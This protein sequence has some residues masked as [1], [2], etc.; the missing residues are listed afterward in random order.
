[1]S[2]VLV[3]G[4]IA[5]DTVR[6]PKTER[7][8]VLGGSCT[9]FAVAAS[10]LAGVQV[11][12]AVGEDFPRR[13]VRLLERH[14]IDLKGLETKP[15]EKTFR[16]AGTYAVN[17]NDRTTDDLQFGALGTF[18]PELPAS[19]RKT[20][21]V[22]LANGHPAHQLKVLDQMQGRPFAVCDTI[23]HYINTESKGVRKVL[24]A[25]HGAILN[26]SEV[27]LLTGK[28]NTP[29]AARELLK[30]GPDFVV[31]KK[32]EHGALLAHKSGLYAIPAYPLEKVVDPTGAGDA[33][34]GGFMGYLAHSGKRDVRTLLTAMA[35]GTATASFTC[36][37]FSL[38]R[39]DKVTR[40]DIAARVQTFKK[41]TRIP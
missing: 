6:T 22:F 23:D 19:Y 27:Q 21:C 40:R 7:Q 32:G 36:E 33:F 17:M 38:G 18:D 31:A 41:L 29:A 20:K 30:L 8:D 1:M 14:G 15:G 24:K 16:W 28:A 34:A 2:K 11:V 26:D 4:S 25:V 13:H 10:H 12:A 35:Y 5:L 9:Y 3:V 37:A 39:I